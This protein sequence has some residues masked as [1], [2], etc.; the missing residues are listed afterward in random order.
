MKENTNNINVTLFSSYM[1][2]AIIFYVLINIMNGSIDTISMIIF[3][4]APVIYTAILSI[5]RKRHKLLSFAALLVLRLLFFLPVISSMS[6]HYGPNFYDILF[7][8][9]VYA[10][11][12]IIP[13]V[14]DYL[15]IIYWGHKLEN[16]SRSYAN[17]KTISLITLSYIFMLFTIYYISNFV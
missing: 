17:L 4:G 2:S 5:T 3:I 14:V 11:I 13:L 15:I 10:P 8:I 12:I 16:S 6:F 1:I 7:V 9:E